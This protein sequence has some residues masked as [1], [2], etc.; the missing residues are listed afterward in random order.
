MK[1]FSKYW[2]L[3]MDRSQFSIL[4]VLTILRTCSIVIVRNLTHT[5]VS[6]IYITRYWW[7]RNLIILV[8]DER[9]T[10]L[11]PMKKWVSNRDKKC[12]NITPK[13]QI[14]TSLWPAIEVNFRVEV[15]QLCEVQYWCTKLKSGWQFNFCRANKK[16]LLQKLLVTMWKLLVPYYEVAVWLSEVEIRWMFVVL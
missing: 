3:V 5:S 8:L 16:C 9:D 4:V 11:P 2:T 13:L 6:Y 1:I 15:K 10:R 14:Q 7:S 12:I